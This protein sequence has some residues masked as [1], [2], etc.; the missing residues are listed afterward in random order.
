MRASDVQYK[1]EAVGG[2]LRHVHALYIC[3]L[4]AEIIIVI[5]KTNYT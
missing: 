1:L 3:I 4:F 2:C 5:I